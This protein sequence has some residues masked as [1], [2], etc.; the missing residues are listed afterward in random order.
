MQIKALIRYH[1]S[2]I[3]Q[4]HIIDILGLI[5]LWS[6]TVLCIVAYLAVSLASTHQMPRSLSLSLKCNSQQCLKTLP[7]VPGEV[8]L[9]LAE[10]YCATQPWN[11]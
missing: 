8:K 10:D 11:G 4:P 9:S 2:K 7:N 5:I 6:G 1:Y 3:S